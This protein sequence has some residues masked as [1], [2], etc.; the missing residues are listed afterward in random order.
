M[1]YQHVMNVLGVQNIVDLTISVDGVDAPVCTDMPIKPEAL[2]YSIHHDVQVN[3]A[4][5]I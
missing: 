1:V 3:Y 5:S 4:L 2:V